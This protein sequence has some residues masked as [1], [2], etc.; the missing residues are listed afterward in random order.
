MKG[1]VKEILQRAITPD[2]LFSDDYDVFLKD[3][4]KELVAFARKL[5]EL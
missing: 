1:N 2:S 4:S 3:R 5:A